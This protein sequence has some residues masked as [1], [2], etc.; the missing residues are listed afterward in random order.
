LFTQGKGRGG[1]ANQK[2]VRVRGAHDCLYL[3]SI[4]F[5]K[6]KFLSSFSGEKT[7]E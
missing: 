2:K 6:N 5:I 3:Q 4:N 1:R 7:A